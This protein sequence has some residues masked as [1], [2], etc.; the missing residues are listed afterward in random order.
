MDEIVGTAFIVFCV[1]LMVSMMTSDRSDAS[2]SIYFTLLPFA[3]FVHLAYG[4]H[5]AIQHQEALT[6]EIIWVCGLFWLMAWRRD[7]DKDDRWKRWGKKAAQKVAI[8][9]HGLLTTVKM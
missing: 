2:R 7:R 5:L 1:V 6:V 4:V 3:W 8:T 9:S